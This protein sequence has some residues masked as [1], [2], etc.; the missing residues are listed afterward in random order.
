M[1][2]PLT[3]TSL[4]QQI[5]NGTITVPEAL[6]A[7]AR[8]IS[9]DAWNCVVHPFDIRQP[10]TAGNYQPLTGVGIGYKDMFTLPD[11]QPFCGA[12]SKPELSGAISPLYKKLN[13]AG[14][15]AIATLAMSE[16]ATSITAQNPY[17]P[18]PIN[19]LGNSY[20]VGGSSSGSAIAVA[21][22]MCYASLGSDTAGSIRVPAATCGVFGLKPTN[23]LL[24]STG[25]F[26]LAPSLDTVGILS[27]SAL[28]AALLLAICVG[29]KKQKQLLPTLNLTDSSAAINNIR[30]PEQ[31]VRIGIVCNHYIEHFNANQANTDALHS[32]ASQFGNSQITYHQVLDLPK[33][34]PQKAE[35]VLRTE[36]A[37]THYQRLKIKNGGLSSAVRNLILPGIAIPSVWYASALHA[38]Q[39]LRHKFI[40]R[41]LKNSDILLTPI[42]PQGI[43]QW[44]QVHTESNSFD[45]KAML[46]MLS[47]SSFVNYL[48]LPAIVFPVGTDSHGAPVS[49]QAIGR[50]YSEATL[51]GFSSRVERKLF[52]NE[53]FVARPALL[54]S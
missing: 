12:A 39:F 25:C 13:R 35:I 18:L 47:W 22:G 6:M 17:A 49:I 50:P 7:Q 36:A 40:N 21:T 5:L 24:E 2:L 4:L 1:E 37:A 29:T 48:G 15:T 34:Q 51:L 32:I 52:G 42:L 33:R 26:P 9:K 8:N 30:L 27:R 45:P 41:Y 20:A 23:G 53:G 16:F 44:D 14:S 19:P 54:R 28:D 3:I 38:R 46:A 10:T 11:W 31:D 43:P